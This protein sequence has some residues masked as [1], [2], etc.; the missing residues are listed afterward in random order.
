MHF[1]LVGKKR[2]G[3]DC[4]GLDCS[5]WKGTNSYWGSSR[6]FQA[7]PALLDTQAHAAAVQDWRCRFDLPLLRLA[8]LWVKARLRPTPDSRGSDK[9][10]RLCV[11]KVLERSDGDV[12][13]CPARDLSSPIQ[14]RNNGSS[15]WTKCW[16][17][18][19]D[20]FWTASTFFKHMALFR[21]PTLTVECSPPPIP[22]QCSAPST[23]SSGRVDFLFFSQGH[24][25]VCIVA[26]HFIHDSIKIF[27]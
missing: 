25:V 7:A 3:L 5:V 12:K 19:C 15:V 2:I 16:R 21:S 11:K 1:Y 24:W 4:N 22:C 20:Y 9:E 18:K 14:G 6:P 13:V 10:Q 17:F 8:A 26:T 27:I 23:F